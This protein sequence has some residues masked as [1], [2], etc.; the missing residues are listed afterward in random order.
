MEK[1]T[2]ISR[3][4]V[5]CTGDF[6]LPLMFQVSNEVTENVLECYICIILL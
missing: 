4:Y 2:D 5:Y 6:A 1:C 3:C